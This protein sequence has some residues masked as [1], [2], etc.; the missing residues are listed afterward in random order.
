MTNDEYINLQMQ[1]R[2]NPIFQA[3]KQLSKTAERLSILCYIS[4]ENFSPAI[5]YYLDIISNPKTLSDSVFAV[6]DLAYTLYLQ[7]ESG[8]RITPDPRTYAYTPIDL[9]DFNRIR[10]NVLATFSSN[11]FDENNELPSAPVANMLNQNYPN[12]FNPNTTISFSTKEE[13]NVKVSIYNV[14]GQLVRVLMNEN[15]TAGRHTVYWEG[16]DSN[17]RQVSSGIYFYRLEAGEYAATRRMLL[18]K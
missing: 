7:E 15:L 1:F 14:R 4:V 3:N 8:Q 16:L 9:A 12:P 10:E 18:M 11:D 13:G 5:E 6:I 2:H 17:N